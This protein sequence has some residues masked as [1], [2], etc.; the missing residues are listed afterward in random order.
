MFEQMFMI[1]LTRD[2]QLAIIDKTNICFLSAGSEEA[3][4]APRYLKGCCMMEHLN[5]SLYLG[6]ALVAI[7]SYLLLDAWHQAEADTV[8]Q[9]A[10]LY[11]R[12]NRYP[13]SLRQSSERN[14][15]TNDHA[16]TNV[17]SSAKSINRPSPVFY[18]IAESPMHTEY[19]E[20]PESAGPADSAQRVVFWLP[21]IDADPL[22]LIAD[23]HGMADRTIQGDCA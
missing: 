19:S 15:S 14:L 23:N 5:E 16:R 17:Q 18:T 3:G 11:R 7:V 13:A 22:A 9:L 8:S 21:Q 10:S 20:S 2:T 4:Q 6:L 1:G 12:Q